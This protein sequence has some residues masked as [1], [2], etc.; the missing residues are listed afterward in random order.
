MSSNWLESLKLNSIVVV[1]RSGFSQISTL[2]KVVRFT[3]TQ[4]ILDCNEKFNRETGGRVGSGS[5]FFGTRLG[6]PTDDI[7]IQ[8]TNEKQKRILNIQLESF[9]SR[10]LTTEQVRELSKLLGDFIKQHFFL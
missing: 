10:Q 8:L 5:L 1:H 6:E 9:N 7:V 2:Q 3:K 4:I